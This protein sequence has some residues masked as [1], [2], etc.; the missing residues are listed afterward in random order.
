[1]QSPGLNQAGAFSWGCKRM[2][3][4]PGLAPCHGSSKSPIQLMLFAVPQ[5]RF[6][7]DSRT[8]WLSLAKV[9]ALPNA[10]RAA[11]LALTEIPWHIR[12]AKLTPA[13]VAGRTPGN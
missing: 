13:A 10:G 7:P 8:A 9:E 6:A 12:P 2:G 11:L 1:M 5:L 4:G 3:C